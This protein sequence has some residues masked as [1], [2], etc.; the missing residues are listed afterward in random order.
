MQ[1]TNTIKKEDQASK[2]SFDGIVVFPIG[3][4]SMASMV[5]TMKNVVLSENFIR[6]DLDLSRLPRKYMDAGASV[7][8]VLGDKAVLNKLSRENFPE[9]ITK[10]SSN[11]LL[12]TDNQKNVYKIKREIKNIRLDFGPQGFLESPI[13]IFVSLSVSKRAGVINFF[14]INKND[15]LFE[16]TLD[17]SL[18]ALNFDPLP[19]LASPLSL[20]QEQTYVSDLHYSYSADGLFS[21]FYAIDAEKLVNKFTKFPHLLDV[22]NQSLFSQFLLKTEFYL[23]K[24]NKQDYGYKHDE[25]FGPAITTRVDD[26]VVDDSGG[27]LFYNF[28]LSEVSN[29][30]NYQAKL[31]FSFDDITINLMKNLIVNIQEALASDDRASAGLLINEV[32]GDNVPSQYRNRLNQINILSSVSFRNFINEVVAHLQDSI[33]SSQEKSVTNQHVKSQYMYP[34]PNIPNIVIS[35]FEQT[36]SKVIRLKQEKQNNLIPFAG[37]D[38]FKQVS[39]RDISGEEGL[40][41]VLETT[42][43]KFFKFTDLAPIKEFSILSLVD[44]STETSNLKS[45]INCGR[46]EE[47]KEQKIGIIAPENFIN[48]TSILSKQV[49]LLYLDSVGDSTSAL[50][51]K[52]AAPSFLSSIANDTKVLVRLDTPSEFFDSY[53]YVVGSNVGA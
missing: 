27:K 29:L 49:K 10:T 4:P 15:V 30:S 34:Y 42:N 8:I 47:R 9:S 44:K 18:S 7:K 40:G 32:F 33:V 37:H 46:S 17:S 13:K 23:L 22:D 21:G 51:F 41:S 20:L 11:I 19:N 36:F 3:N 43:R 35:T 24:Y 28:V 26:I 39:S 48:L 31:I 12:F 1:L 53:F 16:E 38:F 6:F 25:V 14:S 45:D 50:I 5:A 2:I 52:E